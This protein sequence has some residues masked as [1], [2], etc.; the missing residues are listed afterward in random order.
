MS[1]D[2]RTAEQIV[3]DEIERAAGRLQSQI[4]GLSVTAMQLAARGHK[5]KHKR[6]EAEIA[7]KREALKQ[8]RALNPA[9]YNPALWDRTDPEEAATD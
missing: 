7:T 9:N 2:S 4:D 5:D 3:A 8:L 1:E 6:V